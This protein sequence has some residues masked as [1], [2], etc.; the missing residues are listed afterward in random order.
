MSD[1]YFYS[2]LPG[3]YQQLD[4][5][6][7]QPLRALMDLLQGQ[8]DALQNDIGALYDD[9]F[10][11][12]CEPGVVPYI[13]RLVGVDYAANAQRTFAIQRAAVANAIRFGRRKGTLPVLPPLVWSATGWYALAVESS[14]RDALSATVEPVR[15]TGRTV[16][17]RSASA[18]LASTPFATLP[19]SGRVRGAATDVI[20]YVWRLPSWPV[21]NVAAPQLQ[22]A[23]TQQN[24]GMYTFDPIGVDVPL[25]T[26]AMVAP[27]QDLPQPI[28]RAMLAADLAAYRAAYSL[29]PPN[30]QPP[31][32][33]YYGPDRA[34]NIVNGG[35]AVPPISVA[36]GD[37][38]QWNASGFSATLVIDP[39]LGRIALP[40]GGIP[41]LFTTSYAYGFAAPIG[42]GPY[43]RR[44][45]MADAATVTWIADVGANAEYTSLASAISGWELAGSPRALIRIVDDGTYAWQLPVMLP[46]DGALIVEAA[47]QVR[48]A[49]TFSANA[50][51]TGPGSGTAYLCFSGIRAAGPIDI[52]A[53]SQLQLDILDSTIVPALVPVYAFEKSGALVTART[54]HTATLFD[55]S[56][57]FAGG[58]S[59]S[60]PLS[61]AELW[62]PT[63]QTSAATG[64]LNDA[65]SL[66]TANAV[67]TDLFAIGGQGLG[68]KALASIERF[69]GTKFKLLKKGSLAN[70]RWSHTATALGTT[71]VIIGGTNGSGAV[72][73]AEI[74]DTVARTCTSSASMNFPRWN[75]VAIPT[76]TGVLIVGGENE[77]G[78]VSTPEVFANG[79]FNLLPESEL[80]A[81]FSAAAATMPN[82]STVIAGGANASGPA[83]G[84]VLI[85]QTMQVTATGELPAAASLLTA[86]ALTMNDSRVLVAGGRGANGVVA[87]A[88]LYDATA[89]T[90]EATASLKSA[91]A[92]HTATLL[93]NGMVLIAGGSGADGVLD[94]TELLFQIGRRFS[95]PALALTT[96][97]AGKGAV[98]MNV[99][100]SIIGPVS[101]GVPTMQFAGEDSVVGSQSSVVG[102]LEG[103]PRTSFSAIRRRQPPTGNRQPSRGITASFA[104]CT[105][106]GDVDIDRIAT[107]IDSIFTGAVTLADP[108]A[109]TISFCYLPPGSNASGYRC[110]PQ[111]A[112]ANAAAELDLRSPDDLPPDVRALVLLRSAPWFTSTSMES[113]GFAQLR[114]GSPPAIAAGASNGS[115]MGVFCTLRGRDRQELVR[116][117][118]NEFL[119]AGRNAAV[120]YVT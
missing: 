35:I 83:N 87:D 28:T 19:V 48:P 46:A 8:Y 36:A 106:F 37:L 93:P 24:G 25:F 79:T 97:Q 11:E 63:T 16:D 47:D 49:V 114:A 111:L 89:G 59:G 74:F 55:G 34:I 67:G 98:S 50:A 81:F 108:L 105:V 7:G 14:L 77:D 38:R 119:P 23:A 90:F 27:P 112:L 26:I 96:S 60:A 30:E 76:G 2:L 12:T 29:L 103:S 22:F 117:V 54:D 65:R 84:A 62:S 39:E 99:R 66:H 9:W 10:I 51:I 104:R 118:V 21:S 110:Q 88:S 1:G 113:S 115:E 33:T 32:S 42:G 15:V 116:Q 100:R 109:G 71:L 120:V 43:E 69:D 57:L 6:R 52:V 70:A 107:A 102:D 58:S 40:P 53:S 31:N 94:S 5:Q 41:G 68:N 4:A 44:A 18:S 80:T 61:D 13:G 85:A 95:G 78:P 73:V 3:V 72:A 91:R 75:H 20:V 17:V 82:G 64:A 86:T 45:S 92:S 56:V 101:C